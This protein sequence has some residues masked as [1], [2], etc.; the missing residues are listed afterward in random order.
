MFKL[1]FIKIYLTFNYKRK[2]RK[3]NSMYVY[4]QGITTISNAIIILQN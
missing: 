3:Q 4:I 1:L 2:N